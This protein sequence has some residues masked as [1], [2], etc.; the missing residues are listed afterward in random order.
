MATATET[1]QMILS[2]RDQ[3]TPVFSRLGANIISLNQALELTRKLFSLVSSAVGTVAGFLRE[4]ATAADQAALAQKQLEATLKSTNQFTPEYVDQLKAIASEYQNLTGISDE[5]LL[6]TQRMLISFGATRDQVVGLT[7]TVLDLSAGLGTDLRSAALL[8]GK[9]IQGETSSLSRYGI[10]VDEAATNAQKL[11]QIQEQVNKSFGGQAAARMETLGGQVGLMKERYGDLQEE[12]G[13]AITSNEALQAALAEVGKV[14]LE[15]SKFVSENKDVTKAWIKDGV[16]IAIDGLNL[17]VGTS[18]TAVQVMGALSFGV[19]GLIRPFLG[20]G[21]ALKNILSGDF[22]AVF[23]NTDEILGQQTDRFGGFVDKVGEI[24]IE[25]QA[26]LRQVRAAAESENAGFADSAREAA[27]SLT[28]L[29]GELA[30]QQAVT[31]EMAGGVDRASERLREL[32]REMDEQRRAYHEGAISSLEFSRAMSPLIQE[33]SNLEQSAAQSAKS[34]ADLEQSLRKTSEI[35]L[36]DPVKAVP[37]T[38]QRAK[39]EGDSFGASIQTAGGLVDALNGRLQGT[40]V[41]VQQIN[42]QGGIRVA[43]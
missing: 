42:A 40:L 22:S 32:N 14:I 10:F 25:L 20:F 24:G 35:K 3:A 11:V 7:Q 23:K 12:I 21:T 31:G 27:D 39:Q 17:L 30:Q 8:V 5:V 6:D 15:A 38:L 18:V 41:L 28:Q 1:L 13:G 4:S 19:E 36:E 9:A 2:A 33:Q 29:Q 34:V 43:Q 26:K 37:Q 16:L